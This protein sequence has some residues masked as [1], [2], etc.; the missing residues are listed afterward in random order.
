MQSS[1]QGNHAETNKIRKEVSPI[2]YLTEILAFYHWLKTHPLTATAQALWHYLMAV[3]NRLAQK[4]ASGD[5]HWPVTFVVSG[6]EL[7]RVLKLKNR[8]A[9]RTHRDALV[10]HGRLTYTPAVGTRPGTYRLNPFDTGLSARPLEGDCAGDALLFWHSLG[11]PDAPCGAPFI[12]NNKYINPKN[13]LT[14]IPDAPGGLALPESH[15]GRAI[16]PEA[17][18]AEAV[19]VADAIEELCGSLQRRNHEL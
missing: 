11:T 3:D 14:Y 16:S 18:A 2:N 13:H 1:L 6:T 15:A 8:H 5:Y 10:T 9:L 12:N 17:A 7:M 4:D 19:L